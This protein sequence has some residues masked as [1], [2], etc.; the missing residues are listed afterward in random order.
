MPT[1]AGDAASGSETGAGKV[2]ITPAGQAYVARVLAVAESYS[3][4]FVPAGADGA[5]DVAAGWALSQVGVPYAWGG[6][7][8]GVV[9][10]C[11]GLVQ[12]AFQVAG[13]D[14]PRV[15]QDQF[16]A[17]PRLP[18]DAG[19]RPGDLVFFGSGPTHVTH[20]GIY[21]GV[22]DS[23]PVMVDSPHHGPAVRVEA[24]PTVVGAV[25][26]EDLY[27]GATRPA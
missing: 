6:E 5:G 8:P 21:L 24:F 1:S 9:F 27:L 3:Q 15:A 13:I 19:L 25:W 22:R 20:V 16:D 2:G 18:A 26:G 17:G 11:S 4:D 12:A 23:R 10:D 7:T 14:L